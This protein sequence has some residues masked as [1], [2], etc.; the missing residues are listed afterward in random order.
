MNLIEIRIDYQ[1]EVEDVVR[2]EASVFHL[3]RKMT[4]FTASDEVAVLRAIQVAD[5]FVEEH[6]STLTVQSVEVQNVNG[7]EQRQRRRA[8]TVCRA[9]R[10][11]RIA[12]LFATCL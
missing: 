12:C 4:C 5:F 8:V 10:T 1:D 9:P 6:E 3:R 11:N 7:F 2:A